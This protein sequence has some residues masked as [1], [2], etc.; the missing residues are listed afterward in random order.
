[1]QCTS[2]MR[3]TDGHLLSHSR[4]CKPRLLLV[5]AIP[6]LATLDASHAPCDASAPAP[7]I[8]APDT[9][10]GAA[11]TR[12]ACPPCVA[13]AASPG[14]PRDPA[15]CGAPASCCPHCLRCPVWQR[16]LRVVSRLLAVRGYSRS[17]LRLRGVLLVAA[18]VAFSAASALDTSP[19]AVY[20]ATVADAAATSWATTAVPA[21]DAASDAASTIASAISPASQ[22]AATTSAT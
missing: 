1:M 11:F 2:G 4:R 5:A 21:S 15:A 17:R 22:H 13:A 8:A 16:H 6:A 18:T 7:F 20:T 14:S 19:V 10:F 9:P 3:W 12:A